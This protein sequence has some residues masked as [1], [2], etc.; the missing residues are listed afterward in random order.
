VPLIAFP[1]NFNVEIR[2]DVTGSLQGHISMTE[3]PGNPSNAF[4]EVSRSWW[5]SASSLRVEAFRRH[6]SHQGRG[7]SF[8]IVAEYVDGKDED[9]VALSQSGGGKNRCISP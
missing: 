8:G 9:G 3:G 7:V 4:P 2:D 6:R 5:K 1:G